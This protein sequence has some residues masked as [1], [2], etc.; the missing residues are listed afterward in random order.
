MN[1]DYIVLPSLKSTDNTDIISYLNAVLNHN[2]NDKVWDWEFKTIHNTIFTVARSGNDIAG[3]Q[4][5]LPILLRIGGNVVETAKSETSYLDA[6][7]RGKQI[8][9]KLYQLAVDETVKNGSRII[10]GFT[11]ALKAW[12]KNLAFETFDSE[13][14]IATFS[15]NYFSF[16]ENYKK[17]RN[18]IFAAGKYCLS[19]LK[20]LRG[21]LLLATKLKYDNAIDA[22]TQLKNE[23]D[24]AQLYAEINATNKELIHL[25]MN[26]A[27][28]QWRLQ[29]NPVMEYRYQYFYKS[30]KLAGYVIYTIKHGVLSLTDITCNNDEAVLRHMLKYIVNHN[31]GFHAVQYWGNI[32]ND[33]NQRIFRLFESLNG[34][35]QI[36][37]TRNFVYK[38]FDTVYTANTAKLDKWYINGLWTEGFHI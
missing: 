15:A 29:H 34:T 37:S 33:I 9:E 32:S 14:R 7:F 38:V 16:G 26:K 10:W 2:V 22:A 35:V 12:K 13:M 3:T 21:Q 30:G 6:N 5:M 1:I 19:N 4:S 36:D 28:I 8:F 17:S 25:D 24:I 11:P 27:Y 20:T 23:N 31:K 18:I